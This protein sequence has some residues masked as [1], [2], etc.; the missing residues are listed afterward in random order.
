VKIV[1][2]PSGICPAHAHQHQF[3]TS[4]LVNEG[5]A[6]DAG[7]LGLCVPEP[8]RRIRHLLISHSHIDHIASLPIFLEELGEDREQPLT[9]HAHEAVLDCLRRDIFN[10]RV[11]PNLI[12]L[13]AAERPLFRLEP[14]RS[15]EA[16]ELEGM[17]ITPVAMDHVVPTLGFLVE[18]E[19]AAVV[20]A[21]DTGPTD[22]IW[23]RARRVANLRGVFLE[24]T[25]P[26]TMLDFA[27]L[28][29]HLTPALFARE[30][31][32]LGRPVRTVAVHIKVAN[33]AQVV[34]ELMALGLPEL[35]IARFGE[36]YEF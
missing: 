1:P 28:T 35:K 9:I 15:G 13:T 12:A 7:C 29:Q 2:L 4:Y 18:A 10:D 22:A 27:R 23:Q 26:N 20:V 24:A 33:Y 14:L 34:S 32:K 5:L 25:F 3:L 11:W 19:D 8:P 30:I 16:V 17:R 36:A 31:A 6:I 21:S